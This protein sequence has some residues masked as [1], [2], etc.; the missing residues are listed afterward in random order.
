MI[1]SIRIKKLIVEGDYYKRTFPFTLGLNIISGDSYSGK[2]LILKL[3]DYCLGD[4]EKINLNV[5]KELG[6]FCDHV[7]LE[8]VIM[9]NTYTLRR[10]LKQNTT[11]IHIYYTD[12]QQLS[13]FIPK[14]VDYKDLSRFILDI[15]EIPEFKRIK[16]KA[17][18]TTK[19]TESISFRDMLRFVYINQHELGT[20]N[21]L[22]SENSFVKPK[23]KPTFQLL[24]KLIN[25]DLDALIQQIVDNE[26]KIKLL[27]REIE[28]LNQYLKERDAEDQLLLL[29]ELNNISD[30]INRK[31]SEKKKLLQQISDK[32]SENNKL[33]NE[34][35][36][37]VIN[38]ARELSNMEELRRSIQ[39]SLSSKR[40][41]LNDYNKELEEMVATKEAF[42]HY[43]YDH[44]EHHCP[45]CDSMIKMNLPA[46]SQESINQAIS[47]LNKKIS[48]LVSS[49]QQNESALNE[50]NSYIKKVKGRKDIYDVAFKEFSENFETPFLA[51]IEVLNSFI[52]S[53][54]NNENLIKE[55]VRVHKKIEEK[56]N[57]ISS[58]EKTLE[59]LRAQE[60]GLRVE[61]KV[62]ENV[63]E[64]LNK[65]YR[66]LLKKFNFSTDP[67]V[68]YI[69]TDSY[70]PYYH[71]ASVF[72]HESGG[73]V[74]C[75]QI[76]YL[77]SI[78]KLKIDQPEL[79]HPGLLMFDTVSKYLGINSDVTDDERLDPQSYRAIY[80][81]L[82]E[83]QDNV[84]IIIVD[85]TPP[86]IASE[87][88][89]YEFYRNDLKGFINMDLNEKMESLE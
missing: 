27:E 50:A 82:I 22:N 76:A 13:S 65:E 67:L 10:D 28:S 89:K 39:F 17:H 49:I 68:D 34:V 30:K 19:T 33:Y 62:E 69:N 71:D 9:G 73:L 54:Q 7:F 46:E 47:Q 25:P 51:E 1:Q 75:I 85:N 18:D 58:A 6:Q 5:Q 12:S 42:F 3:I 66:A 11:K 36:L 84:Q 8:L 77:G 24:H 81:F 56:N 60:Q 59:R 48:T 31:K 57:E 87:F 15:L 63:L 64:F 88:I 35:K 32:K 53:F 61:G 79:N 21:F 55:F 37:E 52:S 83:L 14:I 40:N 26:N 41:L 80:S 70:M 74:M 4:K 29:T 44:H 38:Q 72:D 20:K 45:L 43:K 23:N 16:N 78:L 2:S 86:E